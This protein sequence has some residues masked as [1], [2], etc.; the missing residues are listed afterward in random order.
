MFLFVL[1][2]A[3]P[4]ARDFLILLFFLQL[5]ASMMRPI[6]VDN[7]FDQGGIFANCAAVLCRPPTRRYVTRSI[8]ECHAICFPPPP[9]F[10]FSDRVY[11]SLPFY[12]D[13]QLYPETGLHNVHRTS[14]VD[15]MALRTL[16]PP[17]PSLHPSIYQRQLY[18][19][20]KKL[21]EHQKSP[22]SPRNS[23]PPHLI[24]FTSNI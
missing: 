21:T 4:L 2:P 16:P 8:S 3:F 24:T 19:S 9:P 14:L 5:S 23:H 12:H 17:P 13:S 11:S 6:Q 15:R 1:G 10:W 7:P 20:K 22:P 18:N